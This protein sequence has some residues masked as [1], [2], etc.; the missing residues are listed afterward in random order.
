M[1][2]L[3]LQIKLILC[4]RVKNIIAHTCYS[5]DC[6][7]VFLLPKVLQENQLVGFVCFPG[8]LMS[9]TG[10]LTSHQTVSFT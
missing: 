1:Y 4:T 6:T 3:Q 9:F 5:H 8:Y 10:Q 2:F 7:D